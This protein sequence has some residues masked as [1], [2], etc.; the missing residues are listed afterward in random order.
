MAETDRTDE[1]L[2][3]FFE[4]ARREPPVPTEALLARIHADARQVQDV[5]RPVAAQVPRVPLRARL[6][7]ALGG[8]QG[9]GGLVTATAAGLWI[10]YAGIADP[11]SYGGDILGLEPIASVELMPGTEDF[12][13]LVVGE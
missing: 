8:W 2:E 1:R 9:L 7:Q 5:A 10:G 6:A 11:A 13:A 4:A 12:A 3:A